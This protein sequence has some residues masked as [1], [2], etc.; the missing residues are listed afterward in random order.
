MRQL[1]DLLLLGLWYLGIEIRSRKIEAMPEI[2]GAAVERNGHSLE[3]VLG[4]DEALR[5]RTKERCI[6]MF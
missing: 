5:N 6:D 1:I 4:F 2:F 3:S